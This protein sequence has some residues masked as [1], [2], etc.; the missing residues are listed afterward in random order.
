MQRADFCLLTVRALQCALKR[1]L[2][3]CPLCPDR[4]DARI[5]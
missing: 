3:R 2:N 1:R 4:V 5:A